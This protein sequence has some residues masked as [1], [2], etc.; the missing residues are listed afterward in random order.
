ME[1]KKKQKKK[2]ANTGATAFHFEY[3]P[4][5]KQELPFILL[6][7]LFLCLSEKVTLIEKEFNLISSSKA[8]A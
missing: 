7:L 2:Q 1:Y 6:V 5:R 3:S 8:S 4:T